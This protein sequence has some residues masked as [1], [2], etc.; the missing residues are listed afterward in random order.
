M[1]RII[2]IGHIV[3]IDLDAEFVDLLFS[4][5][6]GSSECYVLNG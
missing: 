6:D 2:V 1:E 5:F 3:P 4:Y